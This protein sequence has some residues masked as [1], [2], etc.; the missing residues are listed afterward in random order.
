MRKKINELKLTQ[1]LELVDKNIKA[2]IITV[3]YTLKKLIVDMK[4]FFFF[5]K[6]PT[7][8]DENYNVCDEKYISYI[9]NRLAIGK[10]DIGELDIAIE[11]MQK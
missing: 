11:N 6:T 8:R 7:Y 9:N 10:K 4:D 1:V 2:V 5:K 3:F